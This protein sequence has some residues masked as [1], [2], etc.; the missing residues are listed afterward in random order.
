MAV[1][2]KKPSDGLNEK[3][4]LKEEGYIT[5]SSA[6]SHTA[7]LFTY[8]LSKKYYKIK[9]QVDQRFFDT[10]IKDADTPEG[11][12]EA[13]SMYFTWKRF[14]RTR[15]TLEENRVNYAKFILGIGKSKDR[16]F[17]MYYGIDTDKNEQM[18]IHGQELLIALCGSQDNLKVLNTRDKYI[19]LR[20]TFNVRVDA[21]IATLSDFQFEAIKHIYEF[22]NLYK[23]KKEFMATKEGVLYFVKKVL[24]DTFC[25]EVKDDGSRRKCIDATPWKIL[26]E[27]G[28]N[29]DDE[30][31]DSEDEHVDEHDES[32]DDI[33]PY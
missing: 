5:E 25:I 15:M 12:E 24:Y 28:V 11:H 14:C 26:K 19:I 7:Q 33:W 22:K 30:H 6:A 9:A 1:K 18:I 23:S 2:Y 29:E 3:T 21:Y 8:K 13:K 17:K 20:K 27:Y 10:F 32:D 31:D 16:N 4:D